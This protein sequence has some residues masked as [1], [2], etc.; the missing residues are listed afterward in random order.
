LQGNDVNFDGGY[1]E[2]SDFGISLSKIGVTVLHNPFSVN[3][4]LKPPVGG[5]R[6]WGTEAKITGKKRK[7]QPW[8]LDTP[9]TLIKPVPSPTIMYGIV[10][11]FTPKQVNEYRYKYFFL[12]LFKGPKISFLYRLLK[13]P[14]KQLQFNKSLFYAKKLM[15]LGKRIS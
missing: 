9:V 15:A 4:H 10:K 5:Y 12:Y 2:D 14:Y 8:E 7:T 13:I 6:I 11:H 3:L 1:G